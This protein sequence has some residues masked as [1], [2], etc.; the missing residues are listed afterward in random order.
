MAAAHAVEVRTV[1]ADWRRGVDMAQRQGGTDRGHAGTRSSAVCVV[2][3]ET[4]TGMFIAD[5]GGARARWTRRATRR[6]CWWIRSRPSAALEF[7][8]D[9]WGIDGVVGGSQKG[10]MC[11][12]GL[13][14]TGVSDKAMVAHKAAK[15]GRYYFD[16]TLMQAKT[17]HM[18]FIGT[19]PVNFALSGCAKA[20]G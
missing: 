18:S 15:L 20:S 11:P 14:F 2:H 3:N 19:V 6:C 4:A 17:P 10:L 1:A 12:T 7:R 13:S 8:M 5:P 16:W 9:D